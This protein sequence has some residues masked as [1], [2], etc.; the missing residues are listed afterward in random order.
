MPES[1]WRFEGAGPCPYKP[2]PPAALRALCPT[3][4]DISLDYCHVYHLGLGMDTGGSTIFL[5]ALMG[6]YD[7][8]GSSSLPNRLNNAYQLFSTWCMQEQ[9]T[10]SIKSFSKD[11]FDMSGPGTLE[12]IIKSMLPDGF[13]GV[14]RKNGFPTSLG[15]KA[16]DTAVVLAWVDA[17]MERASKASALN[18]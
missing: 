2:G 16:F 7:Q 6:H 12:C 11:K 14:L 10:T 5:L 9:R 8:R 15:G 3:P 1:V 17:D 13:W 18:R 4:R